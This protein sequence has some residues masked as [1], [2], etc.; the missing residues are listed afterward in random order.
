MILS[1]PLAKTIVIVT[2]SFCLN[3]IDKF[4]IAHTITNYK[5][6]IMLHIHN[7]HFYLY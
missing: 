5:T 4:S 7:I 6:D 2:L 1:A 3:F